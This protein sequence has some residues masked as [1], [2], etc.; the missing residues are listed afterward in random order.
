MLMMDVSVQLT[1][2]SS[3]W[4]KSFLFTRER[5]ESQAAGRTATVAMEEQRTYM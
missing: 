4:L 5:M 2:L 3:H 1:E